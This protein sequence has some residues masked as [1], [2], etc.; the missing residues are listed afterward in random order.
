MLGV[1][2]ASMI[3]ENTEA[4]CLKWGIT[5]EILKMEEGVKAEL[6]GA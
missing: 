2:S 4:T 1:E 5:L 6:S 3:I